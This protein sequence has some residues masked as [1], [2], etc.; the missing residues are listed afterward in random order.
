MASSQRS[1][2]LLLVIAAAGYACLPVFTKVAYESGLAPLDFV[3]WRFVFA[4]PCIW[5]IL[6]L[7]GQTGDAAARSLPR[8]RLIGVGVIFASTSYCSVQAL[9]RIDASLYTVLLYSYPAMVALLL[10]AL[11]EPLSRR[12]WFAL[13]LTL[14][15][16]VLTVRDLEQALQGG[17]GEGILFAIANGAF[18]AVYIV[19]SSRL[20]RGQSAMAMA[21]AFSISGTLLAFVMMALIF[22]LKAPATSTGW[23]VLLA[24]AV[25]STAGPIFAFYAGMQRVGAGQ[26]A[27]ISTLE[28]V[29]VL[30]LSFLLLNERLAF[31]QIVG[32]ALILLA[33]ILLQLRRLPSLRHARSKALA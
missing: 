11:G 15:G 27:I 28:P 5:L 20:L 16:V 3:I 7:T 4:T 29:I 32:G 25:V 30:V 33:A 8:W 26:A 18:Y 12:G 10:L 14:I 17:S 21:S 6:R 13:A 19:I 9:V 2:F 31:Q 24:T 1:G 22:G 23:L